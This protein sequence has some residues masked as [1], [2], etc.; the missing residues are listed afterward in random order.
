MNLF[1]HILYTIIL[2]CQLTKSTKIYTETW[3][4][5]VHYNYT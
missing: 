1:Q 4:L 5:I 3:L 2:Y